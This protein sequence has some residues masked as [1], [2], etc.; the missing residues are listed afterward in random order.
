MM[1][2]LITLFLL[3]FIS[4]VNA[5][6]AQKLVRS[7][8]N[9]YKDGHFKNAEID[10][11]KALTK[12]PNSQKAAFNL[13]NSLY[14]QQNFEE[15]AA[16]YLKIGQNESKEVPKANVYYNLGNS[17]LENKK[18]KESID[19]YKMALRQ[20]PK[21]EDTRYNL[22][23]AMTKLQQQK[24]QEQNKKQQQK[25]EQQQQKQEQQ[26]Q[27]KPNMSKQDANRMLNAMNN[28]EKR[29]LDKTKNKQNVPTQNMPEKDW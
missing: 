2:S 8:N 29:T 22:S 26:P 11:R 24:N 10:Y 14:K 16:Q 5:Q 4:L 12:S 15:A 25:Q 20:N 6:P 13:G 17:L 21:D 1:R 19:A 18:Y 7:G 27:P 23:Y 3:F 28:N 9:E